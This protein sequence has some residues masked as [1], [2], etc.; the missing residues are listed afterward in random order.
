MAGGN[1]DDGP[2]NDGNGE[3]HREDREDDEGARLD[4]EVGCEVM[5]AC[6]VCLD[7][8]K[9]MLGYGCC[10]EDACGPY[11]EDFEEAF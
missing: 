9:G 7:Q 4:L 5:T 6:G 2:I 11:G 1:R 3:D 8:V 10:Y